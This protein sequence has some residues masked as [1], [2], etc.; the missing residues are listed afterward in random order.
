[1][2]KPINPGR[3]E[4]FKK[5]LLGG[6]AL[7]TLSSFEFNEKKNLPLK[8][9]INHGVCLWSMRPLTLEEL[10]VGA[11]SLGIKGID[12]IGPST[13]DT[14]KK[15]DL[16]CSMCNGAEISI[17]DGWNDPKFHDQLVKNYLEIIPIVA[18]YGFKNLIAF[19]GNRRGMDD[20]TG[21]ENCVTGLKK[22]LAE[23]EKHGVIIQMELLN[24]KVDHKDYMCDKS[25]WGVELCKR[26][27]S[28]NFKL[29]YDIYHMQI[30]EG[31]VIRT[32]RNNHQYFGH[33]HTAGNPGRNELDENQE[34]YYP[35]IMKAIVETGY[36]GFVSHEFIPKSED[37][38]A[39]LGQAVQVCDV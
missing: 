6:A 29:L 23:A 19:S 12:I 24:S 4:S 20:E 3:R 32:I 17:A 5:V 11:K 7:G 16:E 28:E 9:N 18:K 37:K 30:D 8:G 36:K 38:L 31:D 2:S 1:M 13:W 22:V 21:L 34:I 39:A 27:D 10:C 15:Y 14:L 25:P 26:L 33:Y 35:A